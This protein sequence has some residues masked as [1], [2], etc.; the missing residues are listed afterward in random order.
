MIASNASPGLILINVMS[1][2][3]MIMTATFVKKSCQLRDKKGLKMATPNNEKAE[4]VNVINILEA[5]GVLDTCEA[6]HI[7]CC[8]GLVWSARICGQR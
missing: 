8:G 4:N 1:L 6:L 3:A 5:V 2:S 7:V